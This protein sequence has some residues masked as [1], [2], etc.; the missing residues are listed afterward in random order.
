MEI[1]ADPRNRATGPLTRAA[2]VR[3]LIMRTESMR[4]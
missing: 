1:S 4:V 3:A 2:A